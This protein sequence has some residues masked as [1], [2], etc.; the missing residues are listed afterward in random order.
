MTFALVAAADVIRRRKRRLSLILKYVYVDKI[1]SSTHYVD[2]IYGE[3]YAPNTASDDP[4]PRA[5]SS[6]SSMILL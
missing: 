2:E 5:E 4:M 3:A 6:G 1:Y